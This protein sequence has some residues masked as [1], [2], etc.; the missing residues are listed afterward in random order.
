[1]VEPKS[2]HFGANKLSGSFQALLSGFSITDATLPAFDSFYVESKAFSAWYG[3]RAS[4]PI[5]DEQFRTKSVELAEP[6][7]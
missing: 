5:R 1:M 7:D 3:S 6:R 4:R 2:A